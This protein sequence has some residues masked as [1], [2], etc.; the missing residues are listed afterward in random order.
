MILQ[1]VVSWSHDNVSAVRS[2][3]LL[4]VGR[5]VM[6]DVAF[7]NMGH[8]PRNDPFVD[9]FEAR[10]PAGQTALRALNKELPL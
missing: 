6:C 10:G 8:K 5:I 1:V 4:T 9:A 3:R 2:P 7:R